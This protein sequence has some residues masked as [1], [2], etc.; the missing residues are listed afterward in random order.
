M[1][2]KQLHIMFVSNLPLSKP[3]GDEK[4]CKQTRIKI[5]ILATIFRQVNNSDAA[6]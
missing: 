1:M 3:S 6:R 2:Q 4:Q 5:A